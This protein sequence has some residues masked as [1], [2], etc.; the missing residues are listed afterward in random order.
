MTLKKKHLIIM[1]DLLTTNNSK[2]KGGTNLP[3]DDNTAIVNTIATI[4][5]HCIHNVSIE[6]LFCGHKPIIR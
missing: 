6:S 5:Q 3:K 4:P 1:N 2:N